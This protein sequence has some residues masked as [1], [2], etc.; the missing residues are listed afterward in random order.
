MV[1]PVHQVIKRLLSCLPTML[2]VNE[3]P[4]ED[5]FIRQWPHPED[6]R[7]SRT[8]F[9]D[10]PS[11]CSL[12]AR[13]SLP[14]YRGH[15]TTGSQ[16]VLQHIIRLGNSSYRSCFFLHSDQRGKFNYTRPVHCHLRSNA[17]ACCRLRFRWAQQSLE[18]AL[19]DGGFRYV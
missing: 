8:A 1:F 14:D 12:I 7:G 6:P 19:R 9:R 15:R 2:K 3:Q 4:V 11:R 5:S 17:C 13:K 18:V 10:V 16:P